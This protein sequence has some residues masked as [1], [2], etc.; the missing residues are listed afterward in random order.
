MAS[1]KLE[2]TNFNLGVLQQEV[3]PQMEEAFNN[4]E[5]VVAAWLAGAKRHAL[6][7]E[8]ENDRVLRNRHLHLHLSANHLNQDPMK[9]SPIIQ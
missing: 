3:N 6:A 5:A 8:R 1:P 7:L 9:E 2:Y 4:F